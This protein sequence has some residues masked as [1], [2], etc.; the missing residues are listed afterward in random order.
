MIENIIKRLKTNSKIDKTWLIKAKRRKKYELYYDLI[1]WLKLK[2][3]SYK[4]D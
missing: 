1:F 3:I 2:W 4:K